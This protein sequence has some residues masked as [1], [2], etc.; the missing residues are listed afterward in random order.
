MFCPCGLSKERV[1]DLHL[2]ELVG[3]VEGK[4][5]NLSA[6]GSDG[7]CGKPLGAHPLAQGNNIFV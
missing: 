3:L 6:D 4:C 5:Q 2:R 1:V 7:I